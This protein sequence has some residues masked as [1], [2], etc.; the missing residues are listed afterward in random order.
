M[1]PSELFEIWAPAQSTWFTLAKPVLFTVIGAAPPP[2]SSEPEAPP[3]GL[4][5]PERSVI[6][7]DLPG[8]NSVRTGWPWPE[9]G[10]RPVRC[11]M[12]A[13][14]DPYGPAVRP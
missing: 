8:V 1:N 2:L 7:V 10:Y 6:V 9:V 3:L 5:P 11:S 4:R 12:G 14:P 13:R